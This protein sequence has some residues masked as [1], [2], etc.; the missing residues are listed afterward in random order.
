MSIK[1]PIYEGKYQVSVKDAYNNAVGR[2]ASGKQTPD[3]SWAQLMKEIK[4]IKSL[5]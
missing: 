5:S 1:K 2:M 4:K 3:A